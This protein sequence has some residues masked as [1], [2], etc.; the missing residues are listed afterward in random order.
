MR[1]PLGWFRWAAWAAPAML[2]LSSVQ[3]VVSQSS[4]PPDRAVAASIRRDLG[5]LAGDGLAG[6]FTGARE[7]DRAADYLVK[8][9]AAVGAKPGVPGWRQR[10]EIAP[11]LVALRELTA[12]QRPGF[13]VN[14]VATIRGRDPAQAGEVVV[15]G[16]HYDHLGVGLTSSMSLGTRGE[17]HNGADDN[18][19]GTVALIEIARLLAK[20]P[21]KRTVMIV[22]FSGEELGLLGS[23]AYVK[24]P[25]VPLERTV[26]M[27]N[28]DM[29]GRLR[30]ER[31]LAFGSQTARE[32][33]ALLDSLNAEFRFDLAHSGDGYGRSD[34]QSFYLAGKPVLHLFTDLHEDYHRPTDD[35]DRINYDGLVRVAGFAAALTRAIADRTEPLTFVSAPPPPPSTSTTAATPGYGAYLGSIPDM[36]VGGPG[37]RI[38]GAR[39]ESPA[40]KAGLVAGDVLLKIGGHD[41][42]D[43]QAMTDALRQ[44]RPGD[45]V[46]VQYRRGAAVDS[47]RLVL[48]RRGG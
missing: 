24:T 39:P 4:A 34:Q 30:N 15:V 48:G 45:T 44:H 25:P 14:V 5:Y 33:P 19:S 8:R 28:L 21:P 29:V 20:R 32:F 36:S 12:E 42:A 27:V 26:A 6:R 2:T 17:I 47:V 10:F 11:D 43:L 46:M 41:I 3:L 35:A 18:A 31:L 16:A 1:P 7:S 22:A 23:S 37:V 9:F 40:A 38:S 13:G